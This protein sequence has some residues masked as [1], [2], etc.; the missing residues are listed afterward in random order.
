LD[1]KVCFPATLAKGGVIGLTEEKEKMPLAANVT[2]ELPEIPNTPQ[3]ETEKQE[4]Q[5]ETPAEPAADA[6][7]PKTAEPAA[8]PQEET[9]AGGEHAEDQAARQD[10]GRDDRRFDGRHGGRRD[11]DRPLTN[12]DKL[13]MYKK[14]SEERLLD[15]KR[16]RENK[17]GKK[18]K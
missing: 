18:R 9:P 12:E 16:S 2:E 5:V 17:V 10:R 14:Q 7:I 3:E 4:P 11:R 15:I 8:G 6:T 13:R 1:D